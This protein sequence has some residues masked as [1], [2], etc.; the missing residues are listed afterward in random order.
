MNLLIHDRKQTDCEGILKDNHE[1]TVFI[2]DNGKIK[3]CTCCYGC[4]IKT[5]GQCVIEDGYDNM[6]VLLSKCNKLIIISQCYY[7]CFSPFVKNV[8]DRSVCPYILPYFETKNGETRHPKRYGNDISYSFYFYGE[9]TENEKETAQKLVQKISQK[10]KTK[11]SF[12]KS[13]EEI[14]AVKL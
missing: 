5:P 6:G 3:S 10:Q 13:F 14:Q 8:L 7:G 12:Y 1:E 2:S 9:I 4:W 11:V